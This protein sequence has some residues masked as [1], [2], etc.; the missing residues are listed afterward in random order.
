MLAGLI[1]L[2]SI[3]GCGNCGSGAAARGSISL[4]WSITDLDHQPTSCDRVGA[5]AVRLQLRNRAGDVSVAS[6]PCASSPG[7]MQILAGPYAIAV[8]L[9]APDG[10]TLA[11]GPNE[12]AVTIAAGQVTTLTPIVFAA[13]TKGG[14]VISIAAPPTTA[15]CKSVALNGAGITGS[16]ITLERGA[17]GCAPVTFNRSSGGSYTVNCSSPAVTSCIETDETLTT[18]VD[19]GPYTIR[20][21]GKLGSLDCWKTDEAVE[22]PPPGKPL[23]HTVNL[24]HQDVPGC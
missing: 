23:T 17:G 9:R 16:T 3:V 18:N 2:A 4:A 15:N 24:A 5:S 13:S 20:V 6:F 14:L 10:T 21:R 1:A 19:P 8:E 11:T 22:V 7:T 12:T